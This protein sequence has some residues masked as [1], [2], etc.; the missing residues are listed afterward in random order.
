MK[1]L[2]LFL[3]SLVLINN[4]YTADDKDQFSG[5]QA[6]AHLSSQVSIVPNRDLKQDVLTKPASGTTYTEN[7]IKSL[8]QEIER[9]TGIVSR[10]EL[11]NGKIP[12]T[13][14]IHYREYKETL[15]NLMKEA[16]KNSKINIKEELFFITQKHNMFSGGY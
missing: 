6:S 10:L 15:E 8:Q 16:E 12:E 11:A 4:A 14:K 13:I 3:T 2:Y 5:E 7:D 1:R 9:Y